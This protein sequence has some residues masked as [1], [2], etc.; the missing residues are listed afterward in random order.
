MKWWILS[1]TLLLLLNCG[2]SG[3]HTIDPFNPNFRTTDAAELYFKNVRQFYYDLEEQDGQNLLCL[4][5]SDKE[6]IY[7]NLILSITMDWRKD[8]AYLFLESSPYFPENRKIEIQALSLDGE[9]EHYQLKNR[10]AIE[11][12]AF[13]SKIYQGILND[14]TFH[15]V[16][17]GKQYPLLGHKKDREAFRITAYD[18]YRLVGLQ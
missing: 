10:D 17:D 4:R 18:F 9:E 2:T 11:T 12:F 6:A 3:D 5:Q 16:I 7:P 8:E 14:R 15:V 1:L 13:T